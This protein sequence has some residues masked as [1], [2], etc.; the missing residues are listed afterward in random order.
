MPAAVGGEVKLVPPSQLGLGWQWH[1]PRFLTADQI[2]AHR[3]HGFAALG[4]QRR[5]DIGGARA[6]IEASEDRLLDL[7]RIHQGDSVDGDRR[8]L[9]VADRIA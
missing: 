2:T 3:N 7:E 8:R 1:L 5:D 9:A 6:P 4:P